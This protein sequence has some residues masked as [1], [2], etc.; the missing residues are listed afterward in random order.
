MLKVVLV[1]TIHTIFCKKM[2]YIESDGAGINIGLKDGIAAKFREE[3]EL[4][5]LS[6]V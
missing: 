3:E 1:F 4:F 2:V 5:W 6:F